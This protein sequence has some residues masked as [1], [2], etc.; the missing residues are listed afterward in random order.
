[1]TRSTRQQWLAYIAAVAVAVLGSVVAGNQMKRPNQMDK[2]ALAAKLETK[3]KMSKEVQAHNDTCIF[4]MSSPG[5]GSSTMVSLLNKA[6]PECTIAGENHAA[7]AYLARFAS[8]LEETETQRRAN[9]H[10]AAAWNKVYDYPAALRDQH[11]LATT[12]LNPNHRGCW[13]YKEIRHGSGIHRHFLDTE[14]RFLQTLCARP[15]FVIHTR[16]LEAE[17]R[18]TLIQSNGHA[19]ATKGQ[20]ACF[21]AYVD[22]V[23]YAP[24]QRLDGIPN[25]CYYSPEYG[26]EKPAVF[27][28][29]LED[30]TNHTAR[31]GQLWNFLG[32]PSPPKDAQTIHL[33]HGE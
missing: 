8:S 22:S 11:R 7:I 4:L 25:G 16:S 10:A 13:G 9:G 20:H 14:I 33:K 18:S 2:Q 31:H 24:K 23:Q 19:K 27:D 12:V 28:H 5:S 17:L 15:R 26:R 21:K 32:L 30:Y 6:A 29:T 1:M 3:A